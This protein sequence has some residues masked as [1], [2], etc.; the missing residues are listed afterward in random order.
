M[1]RVSCCRPM[2]VASTALRK[3]RPHRLLRYVAKQHA[4][5]H[6]RK[7]GHF[8]VTSFEPGEDWFWNYRTG[9]PFYGPR[10]A[11]PRSR[12]LDQPSPDQT[13]ASQRIGKINS[14]NEH[15]AYHD[16]GTPRA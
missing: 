1:C 9:K 15:L 7:T 3:M 2:V 6:F 11:L 10:L 4:T 12:P 14:I 13:G 5:A 8:I 16:G